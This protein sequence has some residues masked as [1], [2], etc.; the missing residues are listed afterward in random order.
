[1]AVLYHSDKHIFT[2]H[3]RNS[4]YQMMVDSYGSLLHLYY[5]ARSSGF[6]D[7]LLTYEDVGFSGNPYVAGMDRTYSLDTLPQEYPT[8]GTGDYRSY[9]LNVEHADGSQCCHLTFSHY[10]IRKGKYQ[11][12]GLPSVYAAAEEADTLEIVLEDVVSRVEV[13]LLYGVLEEIDVITRSVIIRN[14]GDDKI[15]LKKASGACLDFLS[16]DYEI[17]GFYGRHA[18]ERNLERRKVVHGLTSFG[19]RRGASS[20]Q[21]NPAMILADQDT[22][23]DSGICYGML[24]VYSGNFLCEAEKDQRDQ[25]RLIMGLNTDWFSYPLGVGE[26]FR[27]PEVILSYSGEGLSK[28]SHN[29][30]TCILEHV[31]RGRYVRETRPVLL[32]SWEAAYFKF[33]GET[34]V[35]L[36]REAAELGMDMV[37]MDDGWFGKRDHDDSSLGD[38]QVNEKKLGCTLAELIEK[39]NSFG[40]KFGIWVE[41]E[42]VNEDSD[43]YREHPDWAITIEKRSPVRSRNQLLLDFSRKEVREHLFEQVCA[44]LDQGKIE[45]LKWDMNRS[46]TDVY[47]GRL[48]YDYV[49][50]VYEFLEKLTV[51]YPN[52]L[53]EGCC[54]G[55]GR[56]D[57]GMLYY[58][59]Q[60]WCSDNTDAVNRTRIQYG[61]SFFYPISAV[62]SHVSAVPNHQTGRVTSLH[63][64]GIVAMAGTFGYEL[65]PARLSKEERQAVKEQIQEY[66]KHEAIIRQGRYYR[67]SN[68]FSESFSGWMFVSEDQK[69]A[70]VQVV[71]L[72]LE[73]NMAPLYV[74][75]RGLNPERIYMDEAAGRTYPGA[76]L[77]EC[78]IPLLS[79]NEEY[80]A[81]QMVLKEV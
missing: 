37:V 19:S 35:N 55:G 42:M 59:P 38:W 23:E 27:V 56:F 5:G 9:A 71:R 63:T 11:L 41:P 57:A 60:I 1:M 39:V 76:A 15:T 77:M 66:K 8:L 10:E 75:L 65:N 43:L 44:V 30:H 34:I 72:S 33:N 52:L 40:V 28:L 47:D 2:L 7:Y 29:Y 74:K 45:Y 78:G 58:T 3:T 22:T 50:G 53:I 6:M 26:E 13:R 81:C 25:T 36:A 32:N 4:T 61:T 51:K 14:M 80:E 16:G 49:L 67:L 79:P 18:M 69:E 68:P 62:G 24:F 46:M 70:L 31:C 12:Q 20:H 64:R 73:G 54:G 21:H 48:T 17:L